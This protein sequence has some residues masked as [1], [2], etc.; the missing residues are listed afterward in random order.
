MSKARDRTRA[1]MRRAKDG[2][3]VDKVD[4]ART[5]GSSK[6][7]KENILNS[8]LDET[9]IRKV[10]ISSD[11]F[12]LR[13]YI[14]DPILKLIK[15]KV[16]DK[17]GS[18]SRKNIRDIIPILINIGINH[19]DEYEEEKESWKK[20][21]DDEKLKSILRFIEESKKAGLDMSDVIR[22]S[23]ENK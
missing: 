19:L 10:F 21:V 15:K 3:R 22:S 17:S 11:D 8:D 6:K 14:P 7:K 16:A 20:E 4:D 18:V 1:L 2:I 9:H 5:I 13:Y 23:L 12:V